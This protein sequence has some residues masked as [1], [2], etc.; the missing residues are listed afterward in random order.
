MLALLDRNRL[1]TRVQGQIDRCHKY[2]PSPADGLDEDAIATFE[3]EMRSDHEQG[4]VLGTWTDI[5]EEV[6]FMQGEL[7]VYMDRIDS[8]DDLDE[9]DLKEEIEW[10]LACIKGGMPA[11]NDLQLSLNESLRALVD[12]LLHFEYVRGVIE[13]DM[14]KKVGMV[15]CGMVLCG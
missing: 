1:W 10:S 3:R 11:L 2:V 7:S 14:A 5:Q 13:Q 4:I 9:E 12:F 15:L 8:I 6:G